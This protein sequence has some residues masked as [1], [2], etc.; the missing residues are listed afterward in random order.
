MRSDANP[1]PFQQ[2]SAD[3]HQLVMVQSDPYGSEFLGAEPIFVLFNGSNHY[4]ALMPVES[5]SS[6]LAAP[7]Q[8]AARTA[9]RPAQPA[10]RSHHATADFQQVKRQ[11]RG[12]AGRMHGT[13]A[14][15]SGRWL[16]ACGSTAELGWV[17]LR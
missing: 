12:K 3:T 1:L 2:K 13:M 4:D 10:P 17:G 15:N 9:A 16:G 8:A 7:A 5:G 11:R 14:G 6:Q